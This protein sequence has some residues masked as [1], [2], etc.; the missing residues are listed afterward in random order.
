ML[1]FFR[2]LTKSKVGLFIVFIFLGL[3]AFA[4]ASGDVSNIRSQGIDAVAGNDELVRVGD[5]SIT[6]T[7]FG[8]R[9]QGEVDAYRQQQPTLDMAQFVNA[10]GFDSL[11]TRLTGA[12]ALE[13]FG[14]RQGM[15]VSKRAIDGQIASIPG[16]Q[17][18]NGQFDPNLFRQFLAQ[19]K[20]TEKGVRAD[21]SRDLLTTA[22]IGRLGERLPVPEQLALPYANLS[23]ERRAGTIALVPTR[24]IA[25]GPAPTQQELELRYGRNLARYTVPERRQI[26]YARVSPDQLRATPWDAE[27][28]QAYNADRARF[29][30]TERRTITQVVVLDQAGADRLAARVRSGTPLAQAATAAG[31]STSTK[32]AVTKAALA[33]ETSPA[34]ANAVFAASKGA[35]VGPVRGGIGFTVASVDDVRQV[36]GRSL[37]Q[38]RDE[39]AAALTTR[40]TAD[41]LQALRDRID[42]ALGDEST[43]DEIVA[44]Q[45]LQAQT[46]PALLASGVDPDR[47]GTPDVGLRPLIAA[48]FQMEDG[49]E[50]QLV[51]TGEDGSF[52]L[53]ALSRVQP[54]APR[55]LAAIR[56]QVARDV[57]ADR[58]RLAARRI[59][60]QLLARVNKGATMAAAWAATGLSTDGP[61]PLVASRE[62]IDRAQG[63]SRAPLALM[64]AMAPGTAKLL[65]APGN[66]GWAIIKLERIQPGDA[67]RDQ[68]RVA[69]VRQAFGQLLGREYAEQFSRAAE[70]IVGV[71]TDK[72][73]VARVKKQ[74]AGQ[75]G[76]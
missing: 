45:K 46:S 43:F 50:P 63:P 37:A 75:G 68:P 48:A 21:L 58:A 3:I 23:L 60:Q 73:A 62:D 57:E 66:G 54:A 24:A 67:S 55:P 56:D 34:L 2:R 4:F 6:G 20:L 52:A 61:K 14:Q 44:D 11:L 29:A 28:A 41:A 72:A 32:A 10:G 59:A 53:V 64:F 1:A 19:R 71:S 16:L 69:A 5:T 13:Q 7:D 17:G 18:I 36:A 38:A 9:V 70:K 51:P 35:V 25:T 31:L 8:Q 40:K 22:L 42:D 33:G 27:I 74:L 65:E 39:I 12:T 49:E 76:N 15:T 47:T 26:R 30:P